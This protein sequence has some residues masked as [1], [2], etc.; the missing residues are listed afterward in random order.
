MWTLPAQHGTRRRE[1][2]QGLAQ[3]CLQ[4]GPLRKGSDCASVLLLHVSHGREL[5]IPLAMCALL[6]LGWAHGVGLAR[7]RSVL[8]SRSISSGLQSRHL[9]KGMTRHHLYMWTPTLFGAAMLWH[10]MRD[11]M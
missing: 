7:L 1:A 6:Y 2:P 5:T 4:S 3:P 9:R 11:V 10:V 8:L